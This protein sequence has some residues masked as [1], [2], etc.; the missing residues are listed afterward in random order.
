MKIILFLSLLFSF[1]VY[2]S[3]SQD[4]GIV[5]QVYVNPNGSIALKLESGFPNA[6]SSNQCE[7][8]NGWA[9]L[10]AS[11]PVVK[12]VIIAAK[13]SGQTLK[14]TIE[15]CEGRWFKIKDLYLQ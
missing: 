11:D 7:N 1:H 3:Y 10:S 15:G 12:S 4:S 6:L 5:S 13:T 9:G 8:N 2:A 14:V